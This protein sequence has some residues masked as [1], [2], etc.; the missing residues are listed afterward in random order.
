[1]G[2]RT[3]HVHSGNSNHG[4]ANLTE[5]KPDSGNEEHAKLFAMYKNHLFYDPPKQ[6]K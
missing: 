1:M 3:T 5:I 6:T 4:I 2:G